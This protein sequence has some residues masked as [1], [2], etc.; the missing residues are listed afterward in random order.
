MAAHW[1]NGPCRCGWASHC[2]DDA[3]MTN[4][5]SKYRDQLEALPQW[6][7]N[8][9]LAARD[10]VYHSYGGG[11]DHSYKR[12]RVTECRVAFNED[13][14][15]RLWNEGF[16]GLQDLAEALTAPYPPPSFEEAVEIR[17]GS[18]PGLVE[19]VAG[20]DECGFDQPCAFG[21]RVEA[22]AVYCHNEKWPNSPRKCRR[23]RTDFKHEDC[24]GYVPNTNCRSSDQ[25]GGTA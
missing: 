23:N 10:I 17:G 21:Y 20:S 4:P 1:P 25:T 3:L 13:E 6:A 22:H 15:R 19:M 8:L 9:V 24:P 5:M 12:K 2:M 11:F 7:K 16:E 14:P 18:P